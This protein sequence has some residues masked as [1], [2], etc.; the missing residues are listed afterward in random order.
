MMRLRMWFYVNCTC[1][2]FAV[3]EWEMQVISA[4][5]ISLHSNRREQFAWAHKQ[6]V[7]I[8]SNAGIACVNYIKFRS[9]ECLFIAVS[10]RI[11]WGHRRCLWSDKLPL[12]AVELFGAFIFLVEFLAMSKNITRHLQ[13]S[14]ICRYLSRT[15]FR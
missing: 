5:H 9:F 2:M 6:T 13:V 10:L 4:Y 7:A 14:A 1:F 12:F 3:S 8:R 11:S 15:K